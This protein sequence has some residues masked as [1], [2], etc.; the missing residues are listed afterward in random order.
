MSERIVEQA[1]NAP[2]KPQLGLM[3]KM[4]LELG[5]LLVFFVANARAPSI[6]EAFPALGVLGGPLFLATAMF[7]AAVVICLSISWIMVRRLPL[8]PLISGVL[9]LVFGALTLWFQDE[10]FIKVKPTILNTMF[11][12]TLLGG[13]LFGKS[14]LG[15]VFDEA[16]KLD[17]EGWRKL[18]LRWGLFFFV[19]AALNE[20]IWRNFSDEF[21][22][23]FKLWGTMPIT[24]VFMLLQQPLLKRHSLEPLFEDKR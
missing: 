15:Y 14:L 4:A 23:A 20:V 2:G 11:G 17:P 18:T 21:W 6:I 9:V 1:P 7:M 12:M 3:T 24:I 5:P 16:F 8:M 19:L 22:A 10:T 13:L